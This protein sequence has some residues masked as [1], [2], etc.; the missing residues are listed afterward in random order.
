MIHKAALV[1]FFFNRP[2]QRRYARKFEM[3]AFVYKRQ[4][5]E[6]KRWRPVERQSQS[7]AK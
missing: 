7:I 4:I 1:K 2:F 5:K 6:A 3:F